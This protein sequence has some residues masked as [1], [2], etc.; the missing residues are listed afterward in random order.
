MAWPTYLLILEII[1]IWTFILALLLK[2]KI[3]YLKIFFKFT[4]INKTNGFKHSR[5]FI[6][7]GPSH[8]RQV[9]WHGLHSCNS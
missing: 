7:L 6:E 4:V 5:Q 9:E 8:L 2:L 1:L 3:F